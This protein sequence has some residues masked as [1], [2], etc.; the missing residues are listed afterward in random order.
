M[1]APNFRYWDSVNP[2]TFLDHDWENPSRAWAT[3]RALEAAVAG[4]GTLTEVGP[5]PGVDY[6][7]HFREYALAGLIKYRAHEG[8]RTLCEALRERFAESTWRNLTLSDLPPLSADVVYAR[9]V[10]EHQPDLQ[11]A[12]SLVLAAARRV[13]VLTWY[14]PPGAARSEVWEGVHCHTFDRSRVKAE[15]HAAGFDITARQVF[16][17]ESSDEA[18]VL[19][20][21]GTGIVQR[22]DA[23][24]DE[25]W[26][27]AQ[28]GELEFWAGADRTALCRELDALYAEWLGITAASTEGL[29]VL[30]IGGGPMPLAVLYALPL[31]AYTVV[32]PLP[33]VETGIVSRLNMTRVQMTAE[34][35]AGGVCD[36]AWGYNVLQH[37]LD[38][39]AVLATAKRHARVVR[40]FDWVDTPVAEHHPHSLTSEWLTAQFADWHIL[41]DYRSRS[42][43]FKQ[44][45]SAIVAWR[46]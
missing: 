31:K 46:P 19:T 23:I 16:P 6:E 1:T 21:R 7:R 3:E 4:D 38:P 8:S 39:A 24:S 40:W 13:V 37:V 22:I 11:P 34:D 45:F 33:H 36:E 18:W 43:R 5:G 9:H 32:D 12:L 26:A 20:R 15:L 44:S 30:D 10:L 35:Y 2:A 41:S 28:A 17:G 29:T 27:A 14:R 25:R 42:D